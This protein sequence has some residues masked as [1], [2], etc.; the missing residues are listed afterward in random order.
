MVEAATA[1]T[2][3]QLSGYAKETMETAGVPGMSIGVLKDGETFTA[4]FGVTNADHPL[5]V[6]D[7][8]LHQIGS[9]TKTFTG[10]RIHRRV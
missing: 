6:T 5:R 8:T 9:I 3:E 2:W 7:E 4:G 1:K 10:T